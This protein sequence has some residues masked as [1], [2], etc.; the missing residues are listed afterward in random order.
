LTSARSVTRPCSSA[1]RATTLAYLSNFEA[2][3]SAVAN[4]AA[5][6][7]PRAVAV[8]PRNWT[9]AG[10]DEGGLEARDKGCWLMV[11]TPDEDAE[12]RAREAEVRAQE[13]EDWLLRFHDEIMKY[14]LPRRGEIGRRRR[15]ASPR[16]P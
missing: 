14:L 13:T 2:L 8:G 5:E 7:E 11:E 15:R 10:S 4:N 9:F 16:L 3:T 6:R 1:R 12:T